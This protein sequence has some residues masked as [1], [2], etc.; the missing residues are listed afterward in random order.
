MPI[1]PPPTSPLKV[2][3]I[4]PAKRLRCLGSFLWVQ[5]YGPLQVVQVAKEAGYDVKLFNEEIGCT[6]SPQTIAAHF[7]VV[8][9]SAKTCA[10]SRAETLARQIKAAAKQASRRI[11]FVL[12][13]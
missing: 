4:V 12:G 11:V 3:V 13:G 1:K 6:L 7:D 5:R 2:A 10:I 9:V 8:G